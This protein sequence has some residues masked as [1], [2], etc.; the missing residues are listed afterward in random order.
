VGRQRKVIPDFELPQ[1]AGDFRECEYESLSRP[2]DECEGVCTIRDR[3]QPTRI[4][5]P[6]PGD[7]AQVASLTHTH[8]SAASPNPIYQSRPYLFRE[9]IEPE[10]QPYRI[11]FS[12]KELAHPLGAHALVKRGQAGAR[13][14]PLFEESDASFGEHRFE[15]A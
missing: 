11:P 10:I 7:E 9:V 2:A 15:R 8:Q 1:R 14:F 3:Q 12:G 13:L 4:E 5:F 6:F